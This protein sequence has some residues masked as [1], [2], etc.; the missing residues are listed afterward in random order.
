MRTSNATALQSISETSACQLVV[1]SLYS[2][3]YVGLLPVNSELV[4]TFSS[5]IAVSGTY[6][7]CITFVSITGTF[8]TS[9]MSAVSNTWTIGCYSPISH[10][11]LTFVTETKHA[12]QLASCCTFCRNI[13]SKLFC[14]FASETPDICQSIALFEGFIQASLFG[15]SSSVVQ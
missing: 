15:S 12:R 5:V 13:T 3:S 2:L 8:R 14:V 6:S 10:G 7:E 4:I 1:Q 9:V 11:S